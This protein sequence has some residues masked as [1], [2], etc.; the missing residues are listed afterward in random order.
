MVS[1]SRETK[2]SKHACGMTP[3]PAFCAVRPNGGRLGKLTRKYV[4]FCF[5]WKLEEGVEQKEHEIWFHDEGG[6][7]C[8]ENCI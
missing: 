1:L 4:L 5:V 2:N 8:L 3:P 7:A 6:E